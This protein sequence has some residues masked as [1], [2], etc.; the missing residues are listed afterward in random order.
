METT[1][2]GCGN[3]TQLLGKDANVG[4]QFEVFSESQQGFIFGEHCDATLFLSG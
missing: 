2:T 1:W 3:S 4:M